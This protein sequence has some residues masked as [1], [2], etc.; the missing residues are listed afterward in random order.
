MN[1]SVPPDSVR[2]SFSD[3]IDD[4]PESGVFAVD[5]R[6]FT[7]PRVYAAEM[8][9]IFEATWVFLG[10][11]SQVARPHDFITTYI[12]RQP[13]LMTRDKDGRVRAFLNTCRHRG[14]VVCPFRQGRQKFHVCRYHGWAYDSGGRNVSVTDEAIGGY[15][16]GFREAG[17][18]LIPV[19]RLDSYRG[20]VFASLSTDVP[21]L[22]EHLGEARAFLD[23]VADQ[24]PAGQ[25]E[26]VPGEIAYTFDANW[27]LQFENGL[28]YYHFASTHSSYV[29]ILKRRKEV[30][31]PGAGFPEEEP[32]D[33]AEGQ[34]CFHFDRGH[35]VNWSVKRSHLYGRPLSADP[36][37]MEATR[38]RVGS[39]RLKW[40]LRQRN[41]TIFPNLQVIDIQS[42]QLRT[43]RPLG[44][45]RTEMVSH[46]LAPVGEAPA[47]RAMRIRNYEDFFNPSGLASSDDNVM[48]E[49]CQTGYA[50][51]AGP[52]QGYLRG[53]GDKGDA[54][55]HAAELGIAPLDAAFGPPGFGDETNFHPGYREWR[56]LMRR[57]EEAAP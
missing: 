25:L 24:S 5:R 28:D 55:P 56:R 7:D 52:T 21:D 48:Y 31:A 54:G 30:A 22:A 53:L 2:S 14:T 36:D 44:P 6:V 27:K 34:G 35:A 32:P 40:M 3:L 33:E 43:W 11:A 18:D 23:L 1:L 12:G 38:A 45:N 8:R 37:W 9:H 13:V 26:I 16:D 51:E 39:V 15:P 50:A 49:F 57:G 42:A 46:C 47:L 4:R 41:L 29:D 20:F 19:A 10:L 17:H